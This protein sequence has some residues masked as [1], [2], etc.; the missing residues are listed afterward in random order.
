MYRIQLDPGPWDQY[1][2]RADNINLPLNEVSKKYMMESNLYATQLFEALQ[3]QQSMQSAVAAAG[4]GLGAP[5]PAGT[6]TPTPTPTATPTPTPTPTSTPTPTPTPTGSLIAINLCAPESSSANMMI[7]AYAVSGSTP[8]A[9]N[10][11]VSV[12]FD[13]TG[14]LGDILTGSLVIP[15]GSTC[16]SSSFSIGLSQSV[17]TFTYSGSV[18][19]SAYTTLQTGTYNYM[20][21]S[22]STSSSCPSCP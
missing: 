13:W 20:N 9:V 21:G 18:I 5:T 11:A 14:H 2:K 22:T 12:G 10:T 8:I 16:I 1:V 17:S 6:A 4:A 3:Q 19:P 7:Y 15:S